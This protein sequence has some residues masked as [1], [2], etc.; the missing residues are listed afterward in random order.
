MEPHDRSA[1]DPHGTTRRQVWTHYLETDKPALQPLAAERFAHFEHGIRVVHPD[2]HVEVAGSFYPV[3]SALL[4]ASL[5]VR[6]DSH[7][8]RIYDGDDLCR[9]SR[10]TAGKGGVV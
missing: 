8:V 4:G 5:K 9:E 3:S 6:W 10:S 1:P 7:L 2:A